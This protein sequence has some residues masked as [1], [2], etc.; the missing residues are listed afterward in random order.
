MHEYPRKAGGK[1]SRL[2]SLSWALDDRVHYHHAVINRC[3]QPKK[4]LSTFHLY[5]PFFF[6]DNGKLDVVDVAEEREVNC[7]FA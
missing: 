6:L 4:I 1:V 5:L 2:E 3:N 7:L